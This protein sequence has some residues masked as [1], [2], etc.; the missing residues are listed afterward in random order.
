MVLLLIVPWKNLAINYNKYQ[1]KKYDFSKIV[2]NPKKRVHSPAT[3]RVNTEYSPESGRF[4]LYLSHRYNRPTNDIW[5]LAE[6]SSY[7]SPV[8]VAHAVLSNLSGGA[9]RSDNLRLPR[10]NWLMS[11]TGVQRS[12]FKFRIEQPF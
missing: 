5:L 2:A 11:V 7:R 4:K 8:P 3:W 12:E 10:E 6:F 9:Y 1:A